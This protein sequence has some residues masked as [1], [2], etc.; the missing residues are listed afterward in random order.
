MILPI[1]LLRNVITERYL[2]IFSYTQ[3]LV[4]IR[5]QINTF[6]FIPVDIFSAA[7]AIIPTSNS[8]DYYVVSYGSKKV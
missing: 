8:H 5:W 1:K 2:V 6:P 3:K 7:L 4:E